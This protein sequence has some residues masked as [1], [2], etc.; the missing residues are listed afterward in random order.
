MASLGK[1]AAS[2]V[3]EINNPVS[4]MLNLILLMRRITEEGCLQERD[5]ESFLRYL[6]LMETETRRVSRIASNLLSFSRESRLETSQLNLNA[7]LEEVLFLSANFFKIHHVQVVKELD[8]GLPDILGDGEQLKQVFMNLVSNAVE[9]ME[10]QKKRS[11]R[12]KTTAGTNA[13]SVLFE[14]SG[15]GIPGN[16]TGKIF[17][18]FFS[19]KSRGKGVGLGLSVAY[20]IIQQHCG[21]IEVRSAA[22]EGTAIKI[23]LP[24]TQPKEIYE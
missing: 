1:L 17:D 15:C 18:P 21:D 19:T 14:D 13:V 10:E 24:L 9:A 22:N 5:L 3:H 23:T 16:D 2:V 7:V 4:G 6:K 8:P 12:V 20:G 11:I